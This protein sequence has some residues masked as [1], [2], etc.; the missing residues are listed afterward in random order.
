[1]ARTVALNKKAHSPTH[2]LR[3]GPHQ[4]RE[5]DMI[6][7]IRELNVAELARVIGGAPSNMACEEEQ[8]LRFNLGIFGTL[9]I[10]DKDC[11]TSVAFTSGRSPS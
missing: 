7:E 10:H 9:Y 3:N 5:M 4:K 11:K 2:R 1:M 8:N 6:S